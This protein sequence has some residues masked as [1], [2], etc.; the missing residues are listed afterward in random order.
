[1]AT[2][3]EGGI[4]LVLLI[5]LFLIGALAIVTVVDILV[6]PSTSYDVTRFRKATWAASAI[7]LLVATFFVGYVGYLELGFL[8]YYWIAVRPKIR[9]VGR[10]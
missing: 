3:G 6:R 5:I 2:T 8:V 4:V 1:M 9:S 10:P 7:G